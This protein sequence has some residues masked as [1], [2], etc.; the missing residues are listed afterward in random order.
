MQST[1]QYGA[2]VLNGYKLC[3]Q[4]T[5]RGSSLHAACSTHA[6]KLQSLI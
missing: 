1:F 2:M 6:D 4:A 3:I 5:S